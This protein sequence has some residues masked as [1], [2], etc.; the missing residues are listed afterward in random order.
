MLSN[1][2]APEHLCLYI[3]NS[4]SYVDK[5]PM[6]GSRLRGRAPPVVMGDL[7]WPGP[8]TPLTPPAPPASPRP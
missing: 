3:K 1:L 6:P 5:I 4:E 7:L 2:Y 8:R